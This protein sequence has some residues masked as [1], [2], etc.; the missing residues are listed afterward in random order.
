M[1]KTE[2]A[3]KTPVASIPLSW[4]PPGLER[5]QGRVWRVIA[6][7]WIGSLVLVLPLLWALA[8]EQP[9]YSLRESLPRP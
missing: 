4:P 1:S 9:F 8:V 5:L 3:R 6:V 2:K 7:G